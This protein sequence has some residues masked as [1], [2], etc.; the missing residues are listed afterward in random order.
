MKISFEKIRSNP[1][2]DTLAPK[3]IQR[4]KGGQ[5]SIIVVDNIIL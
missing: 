4:I 2:T 1:K 3:E 5:D